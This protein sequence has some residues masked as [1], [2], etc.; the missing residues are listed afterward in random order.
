MNVRPHVYPSSPTL[1]THGDVVPYTGRWKYLSCSSRSAKPHSLFP[2]SA[3]Y[4]SN[5]NLFSHGIGNTHLLFSI[6]YKM[7]PDF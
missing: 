2:I 5:F 1:I 7:Q 3:S 6:R 4:V